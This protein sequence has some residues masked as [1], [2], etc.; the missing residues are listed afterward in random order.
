MFPV[1]NIC[2]SPTLH[3]AALTVSIPTWNWH[4]RSKNTHISESSLACQNVLKLT[5]SNLELQQFSRGVPPDHFLG[6]GKKRGKQKRGLG[7]R[8][9]KGEGR[10]WREGKRRVGEGRAPPNNNL[11]LHHWLMYIYIY[12][13]FTGKLSKHINTHAEPCIVKPVVSFVD[14]EL[15]WTHDQ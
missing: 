12:M 6:R 7:R 15:C 5:Y 14:V 2:I 1:L 4:C 3:Q 10:G 11:S 13:L 8:K 9:G